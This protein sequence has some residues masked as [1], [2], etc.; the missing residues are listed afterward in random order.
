MAA[1]EARLA[2]AEAQIA[3]NKGNSDGDSAGP[4][5]SP[6]ANPSADE[7]DKLNKSIKF[8]NKQI[9]IL[10]KNIKETEDDPGDDARI[11]GTSV[12]S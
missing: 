4:P 7:D 9:A 1:L 5:R 3:A 10:D 6:G 12:V 11:L 8:L 2:D